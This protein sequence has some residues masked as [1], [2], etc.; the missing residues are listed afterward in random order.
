[1]A[2]LS[3]QSIID[4]GGGLLTYLT[5][6]MP[7]K[8][9][10]PKFLEN[11]SPQP[12]SIVVSIDGSGEEITIEGYSENLSKPELTEKVLIDLSKWNNEIE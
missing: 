5:A 6:N 7:E 12:W 10:L 1:M 9:D 11:Q 3:Y 4:V 8:S 2:A